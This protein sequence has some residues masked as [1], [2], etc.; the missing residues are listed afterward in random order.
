MPE[1]GSKDGL[2][3]TP[4]TGDK[5][6]VES[7]GDSPKTDKGNSPKDS[8]SEKTDELKSLLKRVKT[9]HALIV[10]YSFLV[11][12]RVHSLDEILQVID[13]NENN[14]RI[15]RHL[16][17]EKPVLELYRNMVGWQTLQQLDYK[18]QNLDRLA[19]ET[20]DIDLGEEYK[21]TPKVVKKGI[22]AMRKFGR[23]GEAK[24]V[25]PPNIAYDMV[26]QMPADELKELLLSGEK[27]LDLAAKM[28]EFAIAIVR[29]CAEQD[30]GLS[31]EALK[32]SLL[33]I[34]MCG[35]TY[36]FTRKVYELLGL[37]VKCIAQPEKLN[38]YDLLKVKAA[39]GKTPD[40]G[41][42]KRILT[43][44]KD[45][46]TI[47]I[48][49]II[50]EEENDMCKKIGMVIS[51][52]PYQ[53]KG[54]SGGTNDA[55]IY[56]EY[57]LIGTNATNRYSILIIKA[58]W[59]STGRDNLVGP[60]RH[61][62]TSCRSLRSMTNYVQADN[63]FPDTEIK[64]GICFYFR[65]GKYVGNC[66]YTLI[67]D[68]T[69]QDKRM[70]DLSEFDILIRDPRTVEIVRKV[71]EKA[72]ED[73]CGFVSSIISADTPF[74]IPTNPDKSEKTPFAVSNEKTKEFDTVLFYLKKK[75][76][77]TAYVRSADII[78]NAVDVKFNKVFIP[79]AYGA[80]EGY[81]H[82][83]LGDPEIA[84]KQ[85][86]CSQTYLY[87]KFNSHRE[88][89]NFASYLRTSFCRILVSAIKITQHSQDRVY[90]FVPMQ[91]FTSESD[92]D[93]SRPIPEID[94]QLYAK[95]GLT[96]DEQKFIESMIKPM[97]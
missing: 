2:T 86:V 41:R 79:G 35:V 55:P 9:Y 58:A 8:P 33:A 16:G 40:Y 54:A 67:Q 12:E 20:R 21:D 42:I 78:E 92:I 57:S 66:D 89:V 44:N 75:H 34:P 14:R 53:E 30:I 62:M 1:L 59:T 74:G 96:E 51:N 84:P 6:D 7:E 29:R 80:G 38:T 18:I 50:A 60:F 93:W 64:G 88:A 69:I 22:V 52:P 81:P 3:I 95:Y 31:S 97:E 90:R 27:V 45:F 71:L 49:D 94:Q 47:S 10:F 11:P 73:G 5:T 4:H 63:V 56:Q 76:R 61:D 24:I 82:Q 46:N 77:C 25:T 13:K 26:R 68:K 36:E 83:I 72:K 65:D 48:G 87:A 85:S 39:D 17:L 23:L 43:Q 15:A 37:D 32:D 28:G 19:N 70:R 91:N